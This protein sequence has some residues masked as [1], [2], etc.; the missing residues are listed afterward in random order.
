ML[1]QNYIQLFPTLRE[2]RDQLIK[3]QMK[4]IE[5]NITPRTHFKSA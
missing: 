5:K 4:D 2:I 3:A 1:F